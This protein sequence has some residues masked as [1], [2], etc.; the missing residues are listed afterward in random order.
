LLL[1]PL[2]TAGCRACGVDVPL[3][4]E[5]NVAAVAPARAAADLR[6][7]VAAPPA[8]PLPEPADLPALWQLALVYNPSLREAAADLEAARG[9]CEQAGRYPNP[10]LVY[11][12]DTIGAAVAPEG[13]FRVEVSQEFV[14]A[15]KNGLDRQIAARGVDEAGVALLGRKLAVL[16]RVRRACYDYAGRLATEAAGAEVVAALEEAVAGTRAQV[17]AGRP[18]TDLLRNEALLEEARI[19]LARTRA[20][21]E[22]SWRQ[23]AAEVGVPDLPPPARLAESGAVPSWQA[24]AVRAR[25]LRTNTSLR[26]AALE[27]ERARLACRRARAEA[28]PNVTVGAGYVDNR[29]ENAQGAVVTVEAALPLWDRKEGRIHE[30]EAQLAR[31][32]AA[33]QAVENRLSRE[34]AA[35]LGAY[36]AAREQVE[37]LAREVLPRLRESLDLL[38]KGYQAGA[39]NIGFLDVLQAEQVLV[40]ARLTL[41]EARRGLWL[42]VADLEALMQLDLNEDLPGTSAPDPS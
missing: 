3:A 9:R 19:T 14:T 10:R 33:R 23:L 13:N 15:G 7:C 30:A 34:T 20:A 31:A 27:V 26:E 39:A 37:R 8:A 1:L 12:Q 29:V 38:R 42:A 5:S 2:L 41:A 24:N 6:L 17:K 18:R 35:A 21:R 28:V 32:Q 4:V 11:E 25:V 22:A 16:A 36:E 40:N